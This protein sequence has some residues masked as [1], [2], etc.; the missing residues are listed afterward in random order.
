M[1]TV[2]KTLYIEGTSEAD[3]GNLRKAFSLLLEKELSGNMPRIIMGDGKNQTIDK[4]HS[5]PI[6]SGENR[7]LLFDSDEA[8]PD[9]KAICDEFNRA[10]PN[11][12]IDATVSNTFLMIQEV[13]AWIL[14]QPNILTKAGVDI[15]RFNIPNVETISKPSEK[16]MDLYRHS[17]KTYTKVSEFVKIFPLLDS[18]KLK[19]SCPEYKALIIALN[20]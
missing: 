9:K 3:N 12:R 8:S 20:K 15:S 1:K 5:T 4:F 11:R 6:K 13:E 18:N 17:S 19:E 10:K 16:L 14:S 7:F 2:M